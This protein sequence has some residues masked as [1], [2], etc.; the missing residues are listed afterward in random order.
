MLL[1]PKLTELA[2]IHVSALGLELP[3]TAPQLSRQALASKSAGIDATDPGG[4]A[5]LRRVDAREPQSLTS[6]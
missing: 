5:L 4:L 3:V 2:A 6:S 1:A